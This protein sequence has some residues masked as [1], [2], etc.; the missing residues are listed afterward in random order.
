M[1]PGQHPDRFAVTVVEREDVAG[2]QA[3]SIAIDKERFG[4]AWLNDGVQGG[5]PIFH[6][7]FHYFRA[8]GHAPQACGLQIS[9]GR[10]R[11][12][13]LDECVP[14]A[15]RAHVQEGH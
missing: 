6:H 1:A 12:R 14:G 10:G 5:S 9:F 13:V 15:P 2:G 3:T 4:A 7:T 11:G 8:M